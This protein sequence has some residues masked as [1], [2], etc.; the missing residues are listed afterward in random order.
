MDYSNILCKLDGLTDGGRPNTWHARCP[1]LS[2]HKNGDRRPSLRLW[3][4]E[5]TGKL[6]AKCYGGCSWSEVAAAIGEPA[7]SWFPAPPS[8]S[9]ALRWSSKQTIKSD[10]MS[11]QTTYDYRDRDGNLVFQVCRTVD[12]DG[13]KGFFQRRPVPGHEGWAVGLSE[14]VYRQCSDGWW[15]QTPTQPDGSVTVQLKQCRPVLYRLPE[16]IAHPD[17]P[18][19]VVEGEKDADNLVAVFKGK[20]TAITTA[21]MGAGKWPREFGG[22]LSGRRVIIIPDNDEQ[23]LEHALRV[24]GS[25][26]AYGAASVRWVRWPG[27][28]AEGGDI[29]DW[30]LE[31]WPTGTLKDKYEEV[32]RLILSSECWK[33]ES[34]GRAAA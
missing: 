14:G 23:G 33:Q 28:F 12:K 31:R 20:P 8:L 15:R 25:A 30:L 27:T 7:Q 22:Y 29:T 13:N 1:N 2:R 26:I 11:I 6:R 32:T 16:L 4:C 10:P 17:W 9:A 21:P 18:A 3:V 5:Q 34:T 19:I 24:V